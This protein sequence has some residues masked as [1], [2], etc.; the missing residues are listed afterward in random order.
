M[1]ESLNNRDTRAFL[2]QPLAAHQ[3]IPGEP[4]LQKQAARLR[5]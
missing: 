5:V 2:E 4:G 3:V 1:E